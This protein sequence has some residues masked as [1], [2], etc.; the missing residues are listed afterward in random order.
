[1][2]ATKV[3]L[4]SALTVVTDDITTMEFGIKNARTDASILQLL[5]SHLIVDVANLI[6]SYDVRETRSAELKLTHMHTSNTPLIATYALQLDNSDSMNMYYQYKRC[7]HKISIKRASIL[8]D[9]YDAAGT[10]VFLRSAFG[11]TLRAGIGLSRYA[12]TDGMLYNVKS[13]EFHLI[14]NVREHAIHCMI[15]RTIICKFEKLMPK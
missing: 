13:N 15:L 4:K 3:Y 6:V 2:N 5:T 1:M 12:Y 8:D 9:R 14:N 10:D 11:Y 7:G